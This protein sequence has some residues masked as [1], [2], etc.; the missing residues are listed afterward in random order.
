LFPQWE[1]DLFVTALAGQE[2]RRLDLNAAGE[3]VGQEGLL[4]DRE[5]RF[6]DVRVGPDGALYVL[7][8]SPEGQVLRLTPQR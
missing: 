2:L 5:Q 8:D 6:R 4:G 3:V 1:G 7:T